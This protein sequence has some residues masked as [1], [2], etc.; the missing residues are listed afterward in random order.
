MEAVPDSEVLEMEDP[1]ISQLRVPGQHNENSERASFPAGSPVV[2]LSR[3]GLRAA[4]PSLLAFD[5][6]G[7]FEE[8]RLSKPLT[9]QPHETTNTPNT[10][11]H[12][13]VPVQAP[14]DPRALIR[15]I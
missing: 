10:R 12:P 4:G 9:P 5:T 2:R 13:H 8:I 7:L 15:D 6:G 1:A 3:F 14:R 11:P